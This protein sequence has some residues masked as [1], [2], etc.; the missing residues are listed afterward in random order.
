[1]LWRGFEALSCHL[2]SPR[3][4][5]RSPTQVGTDPQTSWGAGQG[6][7]PSLPLG[8]WFKPMGSPILLS[9]RPRSRFQP[10]YQRGRGGNN[11]PP[12]AQSRG[13]Q[14]AQG[15]GRLGGR[16]AGPRALRTR[17]KSFYFSLVN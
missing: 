8:L 16:A 17:R 11:V 6:T 3:P 10:L 1:M 13:E 14:W 12:E 5:G 7:T 4:R 9:P 15:G 2:R